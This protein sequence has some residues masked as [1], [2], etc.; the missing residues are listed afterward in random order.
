M[1]TRILI[2][3][4]HPDP[5]SGRFG[6]A[7]T[8]AYAEGATQA[9]H[10]IRLIDL[11]TRDFDL[12]RT[13]DDHDNGPVPAALADAQQAIAWAQHIVIVFPLWLGGMPALLKGFLEQVLRPGFAY[14]VDGGWKRLLN[15]RSARIV[16]TM[17]MPALAYRFWFGGHGVRQLERSILGFVGI[18]PVATTLIGNI[19]S[20]GDDKRRRWLDRM[21]SL[22]KQVR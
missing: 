2:L 1:Q 22:G 11:A 12:L 4:G 8:A 17:G 6:R 19:E 15:G 14:R 20:M 13:K 9:G 16:V 5:A 18:K 7:L 3:Q 21:R 10:E